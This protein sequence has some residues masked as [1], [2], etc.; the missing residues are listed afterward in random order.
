MAAQPLTE[1]PPVLE[2]AERMQEL[3][4][5]T[6][7][8]PGDRFL[9]AREAASTFRVRLD[10]ANRALQVLV[11]RGWLQRRQRLGAVVT[12]PTRSRLSLGRIHIL[13]QEDHQRVERGLAAPVQ[14][15]LQRVLPGCDVV[16][17]VIPT[18]GG[19]DYV[20]TM[21]RR[22]G[23]GERPEGLLLRRCDYPTQRRVADSGLPAI[24]HG[25]IYPGVAL[26][27]VNMDGRQAG[28]LQAR[29]LVRA[30]CARVVYL[31]GDRS[32]PGEQEL[33]RG[34]RA[35]V[36][37][38]GLGPTAVDLI[39]VPPFADLVREEL[40]QNLVDARPDRPVGVVANIAP[41]ADAALDALGR[42]GWED[43]RVR[44]HANL[45]PT[46]LGARAPYPF[47]RPVV[48]EEEQGVLLGQLLCRRVELPGA[49][50]THRL[51]PCELV[52]PEGPCD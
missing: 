12:D 21:L 42:L 4:R 13:F 17:S 18:G 20:E 16:V 40:A 23:A 34:L 25:S 52:R 29:E 26:S 11:Q 51:V 46:E 5:E 24:V 2:L 14:V 48:D 37:A 43:G 44:V 7:L 31:R 36:E 47:L 33:L 19:A 15:G 3:I 32:V 30:G 6:G 1:R 39:E 8:A 38:E 9:T 22:L 28:E 27:S 49:A 45:I 41:L 10:L 50:N 35:G